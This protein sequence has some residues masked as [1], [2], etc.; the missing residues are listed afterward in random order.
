MGI[1]DDIK[2]L[3]FKLEEPDR[4]QIEKIVEKIKKEKKDPSIRN[5]LI[6]GEVGDFLNAWRPDIMDAIVQH[7]Q[8]ETDD[9]VRKTQRKFDEKG[10]RICDEPY[11]PSTDGVA[12]CVRC[13]KYICKDHNYPE[14]SR[15]CYDCHVA[16]F[17]K[18]NT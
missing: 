17:G 6:E 10:N 13:G 5:A 16:Q 1:L 8:G 11:C 12:Q 14:G 2:K 3:G 15:C 9:W 18:E 4:D 7:R